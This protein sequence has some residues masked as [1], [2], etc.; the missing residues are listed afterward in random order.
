MGMSRIVTAVPTVVNGV[1]TPAAFGTPTLVSAV[2]A[3]TVATNCATPQ[4]DQQRACVL[5]HPVGQ[6]SM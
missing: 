3:C 6:R 1:F 5:A 4:G 2:W